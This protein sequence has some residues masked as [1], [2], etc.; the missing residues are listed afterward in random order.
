MIIFKNGWLIQLG[1]RSLG[2]WGIWIGGILIVGLGSQEIGSGTTRSTNPGWCLEHWANCIPSLYAAIKENFWFV[3]KVMV[4]LDTVEEVFHKVPRVNNQHS[5]LVSKGWPQL[6]RKNTLYYI[7][8]SILLWE[9]ANSGLTLSK[10]PLR[11]SESL[12]L[13]EAIWNVLWHGLPRWRSRHH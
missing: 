6:R 13:L 4:T 10:I 8:H 12:P 5:Y 3:L 11:Y 1:I 7:L 2:D 9:G